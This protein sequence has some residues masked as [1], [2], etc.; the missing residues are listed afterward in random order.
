MWRASIREALHT[1][2]GDLHVSFYLGLVGSELA[3]NVT[4][5][6]APTPDAIGMVQHVFTDPAYRRQGVARALMQAAV[7]TFEAEG[8]QLL[9]LTAAYQS[10]AYRL[11]RECG[12]EPIGESGDMRWCASPG[13]EERRFVV[14]PVRV[15]TL[16]WGDWP[17]LHGLYMTEGGEHLRSLHY[18]QWGRCGYEGEFPLLMSALARGEVSDSRVLV[19]EGGTVTGHA[20]LAR[21][22]AWPRSGAGYL[23][24]LKRVWGKLRL[25]R[26][27]P[28]KLRSLP[29]L[30]TACRLVR[31]RRPCGRLLEF[32]VHP[33]FRAHA[34]ELLASVRPDDGP[35]YAVADSEA[36]ERAAVLEAA[37]LRRALTIERV[38]PR[39]AGSLHLRVFRS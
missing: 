3:G 34:A 24:H 30:V 21:R 22:P 11:Y 17:A 13:A 20:Y 18:Y 28:S 6:R 37:G 39:G 27:Q 1:G 5:Q 10:A 7:R 8:G 4:V 2:L 29:L 15:R 38:V 33:Q 9:Y 12:F 36:G 19:T 23:E 14:G 31:A 32:F 35:V 26:G 25:A 16:G